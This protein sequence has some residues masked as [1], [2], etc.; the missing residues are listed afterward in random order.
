MKIV[1][2]PRYLEVYSSDPAAAPGRMESIVEELRRAGFE[3]VEPEPASEEDILLVHTERHLEYVRSLRL[4][5]NALL[6]V[7]GAVKASENALGGE[8]SFGAIRPPGHHAGRDS[9]WGFCYFNNIAIAVERLRRSGRVGSA[10]IIDFDLH[11]GD[12][13]AEIFSEVGEVAYYH[14]PSGSRVEQLEALRRFLASAGDYDLVA[15]SAGFDR[16]VDDWGGVLETEDYRRIGEMIGE[17]AER[18]CKGR[19]F[20]VLEGGYN[21]SVLGRSVRA[22]IEGVTSRS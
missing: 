11:Y 12:G 16:H 3:F 22:F 8:P 4:Y 1:Y 21:H 20:A 19:V 13:T 6:A 2:H 5:E 10:L 14:L 17:F 18:R 7:G 15:V 9:S